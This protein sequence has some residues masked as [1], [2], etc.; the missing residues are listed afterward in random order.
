ME[1]LEEHD[2]YIL[3]FTDP[4]P[5][6]RFVWNINLNRYFHISEL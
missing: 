2:K 5:N 6:Q 4:V 1:H 3:K